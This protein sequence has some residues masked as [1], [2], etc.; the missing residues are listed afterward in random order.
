MSFDYNTTRKKLVLPEY[1]R[2]LQMMVDYMMSL[3]KKEERT[4]AAHTI[5][6]IMGNLNPQMKEVADVKSKL[7][8]HLAMMTDFQLDIDTPF[9]L[10]KEHELRTKPNNVPYSSNNIRYKH[11]GKNVEFF[12][13]KAI[14]MEEGESKQKFV[15]ML[16]NHMKKLYLTHNRESVADA[17]IIS[18][19][20][21]LAKGQLTIPGDLKLIETKEVV[22]K[23][24]TIKKKQQKMPKR[25]GG[26]RQE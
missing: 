2:N 12:I 7:W 8:D 10:L 19:L 18:D 23:A 6:G 3:E 4:L 11:Y 14:E 9:E 15:E 22:Q 24:P 16:A 1:G 20:N 21:E 13:H 17:Q 5:I 26:R 25:M